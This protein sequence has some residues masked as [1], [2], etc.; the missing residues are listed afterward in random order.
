MCNAS[1]SPPLPLFLFQDTK[2]HLQKT[3]LYILCIFIY[4]KNKYRDI[5]RCFCL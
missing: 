1:V 2:T 5:Y 3:S 4:T